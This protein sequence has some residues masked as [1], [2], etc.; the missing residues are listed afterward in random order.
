MNYKYLYF[1]KAKQYLDKNKLNMP[2]SIYNFYRNENI[3]VKREFSNYSEVCKKFKCL[4]NFI[5]SVMWKENTHLNISTNDI[6]LRRG[7]TPDTQVT[8]ADEIQSIRKNSKDYM[9][10]LSMIELSLD[11]ILQ[12][13]PPIIINLNHNNEINICDGYHRVLAA[14]TKQNSVEFPCTLGRNRDI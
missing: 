12:L 8:F 9:I 3:Y 10:F 5:E 4:V 13:T 7:C 6:F 1:E 2:Q 11:K 14:L